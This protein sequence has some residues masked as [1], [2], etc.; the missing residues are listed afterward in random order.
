MIQNALKYT[1]MLVTMIF[2]NLQMFKFT[3]FSYT[4]L[5][6]VKL[7]INIPAWLVGCLWD[8]F[9]KRNFYTDFRDF[10][11][12]WFYHQIKVQED[13][14]KLLILCRNSRNFTPKLIFCMTRDSFSLQVDSTIETRL[15]GLE[16]DSLPLPYNRSAR[17]LSYAHSIPQRVSLSSLP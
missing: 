17:P 14:R 5:T 1:K 15:H 7:N 10:T 16:E 11:D 8:C 4:T 12:G 9:M 6:L 2:E 3:H 13:N